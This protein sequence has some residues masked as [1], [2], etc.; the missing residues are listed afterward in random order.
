[1]PP[2]TSTD[3]LPSSLFGPSE[4]VHSVGSGP[5][6]RTAGSAGE[7]TESREGRYLLGNLLGQGG[8]GRVVVAED[9]VLRRQVAM[10]LPNVSALSERA[11]Q[12]LAREAWITG[13]LDHPGIVAVY[14][15]GRLPDGSPFYTMRVVQGRS[16]EHA[17]REAT[18][19]AARLALVRP[20]LAA[21]EAVAYAHEVG[22]VHRDLKPANILL[23]GFG[24]TQ[25]VDWGLAQPLAEALS[26]WE[27]ALSDQGLFE[28]ELR[29]G[30]AGTPC[31]MAPEQ[32]R[33][34]TID[35]RSDVFSLGAILFL[36]LTGQTIRG[37]REGAA[38]LD[39][40]QSEPAPRVAAVAPAAP[41]ELAA[42]ADRAL[43]FDPKERYPDAAALAKDL[44]SWFEGRRVEAYDYSPTE[45]L[46]RLLWT[47]RAPLVV[48]LAVLL[49][50]TSAGVIAAY[51]ITEERDRAVQAESQ[52]RAAEGV[53]QRARA[54]RDRYISRQLLRQ[55]NEAVRAGARARAESLAASSLSL[56]DSPE[57]RGVLAAFAAAERPVLRESFV[58]PECRS[59][60]LSRE[61]SE[62]LCVG[63]D[64][65]SLF[66]VGVETPRWSLPGSFLAGS[67]GQRGGPLLLS[68]RTPEPAHFLVAPRNGA[69]LSRVLHPPALPIRARS[70]SRYLVGNPV[71]QGLYRSDG[72]LLSEALGRC[73]SSMSAAALDP[74]SNLL[75]QICGDGQ[76]RVDLDAQPQ[77]RIATPFKGSREPTQLLPLPSQ[78]GLLVATHRG[79][80]AFLETQTGRLRYSTDTG[81]G[82]VHLLR[83]SP[84]GARVAVA[85]ERGGVRIW[86]VQSGHFGP[87]LPAQQ[88]EDLVWTGRE[89]LVVLGRE[90]RRWHV[91]ARSRPTRIECASG[92]S[93]LDLAPD[94]R[95]LALALGDGSVRVVSVDDGEP[96]LPF[97]RRVGELA[98]AVAFSPDGRWLA[99]TGRG[100]A[101]LAIQDRQSGQV[102][103][104]PRRSFYR[105]LQF[106]NSE[107]LL[108]V[109][110]KPLVG[111]FR[112]PDFLSTPAPPLD[113]IAIDAGATHDGSWIVVLGE[114]GAVRRLREAA[115]D[116]EPLF[117]SPGAVA[118]DVG[119]EGLQLAVAFPEEVRLVDTRGRTG[120]RL[121]APGAGLLDVAISAD[122]GLVAAA[123]VDG[124]ARVW[125]TADGA[126]RALLRGH[127][128]R[129]SVL[130]FSP[131]AP[132]L[133]TGGWDRSARIWDL[134]ELDRPLD[135]VVEEIQDNWGAAIGGL[136]E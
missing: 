54:L 122:G 110:Y 18:E 130:Q 111:R 103:L 115:P 113:E 37:K 67:F 76:L 55:A 127:E 32:A 96:P 31:F 19:S 77:G 128:G 87:T 64:R 94:G 120:L 71:L 100:G 116:P 126:L 59:A 108:G 133:V 53:A 93:D 62:L 47:F 91:P 16:L 105:R 26:A 44:E 118:V 4:P 124:V 79:E 98:K 42:V 97:P 56:M 11:E 6:L 7:V 30:V 119:A 134:G 52:A 75:Y 70:A 131:R 29:Q 72:E 13:H 84:G 69:V 135:A 129:V 112:S 106:A 14:D 38:T 132:V 104:P 114:R 73:P 86:E 101:Q 5:E 50:L 45:S 89:E 2:P 80:L 21:C 58:R 17:L 48:A 109:G 36:L 117:R 51:R 74:D 63:E 40:A 125:S 102:L 28:S 99:V 78:R 34:E 9:R 123:G 27:L 92:I 8:M 39:Q 10:K 81:L 24:E 43:S 83:S 22:I 33:G 85:G 23:G 60:S 1:M 68:A 15:A 49:T 65:A 46:R 41:A 82:F 61:G 95:A 12:S 136:S 66:E 35:R 90:L 107:I 121:D 88:I 25:V 57:A 3:S 20:L